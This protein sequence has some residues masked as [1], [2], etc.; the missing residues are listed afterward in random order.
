M[1]RPITRRRAIRISAAAAGLALLPAAKT[2]AAGV[3]NMVTWHGTAMGAVATIEIHHSD[4]AFAQRL[5]E[6]SVAETVRLE[7]M[8]SLYREDSDLV[9]LNKHG[10]LAA[11]STDLV[12]LFSESLRY[13]QLTGGAFDVTVQPLWNLY[14]KHF[15]APNAKAEGPAGEVLAAAVERVGYQH[16][17]VNR[18]RIAFGKPGMGVTLN[19]IAQGYI[20][21]RIIELLRSEGIT[22]TLVDMGETR[23]LGTHPSGRPWKVGIADPDQPDHTIRGLPVVNQ[24]VATSGAYGFRFDQDGRFN[25][26]FDPKTGKSAHAYQSVTVVAPSATAADA[27]S[28]AF[29]LMALR[30]IDRTLA[31]VP[32]ATAYLVLTSGEVVKRQPA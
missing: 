9:A 3:N 1:A 24:A 16:L 28:T 21:D 19:G 31:T 26:L 14:S 12:E 20:T 29:S 5:I 4:R 25:H 30:D 27:L 13:S 7:R 17:L 23:C 15:K 22:Q 32:D 2:R 18:D 10:V 6:R 8:L 11:P